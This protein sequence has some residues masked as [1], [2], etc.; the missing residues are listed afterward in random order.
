MSKASLILDTCFSSVLSNQ[1]KLSLGGFFLWLGFLYV[2]FGVFLNIIVI[3]YLVITFII[4][5]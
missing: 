1:N 4:K 2:N 5:G 3:S